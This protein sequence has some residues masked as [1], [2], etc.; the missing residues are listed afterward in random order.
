LRY[1]SLVVMI[2][3]WR[4]WRR[5]GGTEWARKVLGGVEREEVGYYAAGRVYPE[6]E[7]GRVGK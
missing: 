4:N 2:C 5:V 1:M 7:W 6:S 3:R